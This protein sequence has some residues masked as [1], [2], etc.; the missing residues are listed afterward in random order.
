MKQWLQPLPIVTKNLLEIINDRKEFSTF[1]NLLKNSSL[2]ELLADE[3]K[4]YM[5]LLPSNDA[6]S[7]NLVKVLTG[8]NTFAHE[9]VRSHILK[10]FLIQFEISF[11]LTDKIIFFEKNEWK[12]FLCESYLNF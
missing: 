12:Y 5:I 4:I 6:L 1:S 7:A 10:G 8:N 9:F 3:Q 2:T 11:F